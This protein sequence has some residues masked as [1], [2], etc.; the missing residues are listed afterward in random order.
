MAH[1]FKRFPE[2]TNSQMQ[3]YY[4]Q[5]PH[6]QITENFTATVVKVT[7]GDTIRVEWEGRD[8]D[9][10]V[11]FLDIAAAE[12]DEKGGTQSQ[13]WLENRILGK[14]IEVRINPTSRVEKWGRLLG[15]IYQDGLDVGKESVMLGFSVP[16]ARRDEGKV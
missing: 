6:R 8:F 7:D 1:D 11:R 10:P 14:D 15:A 13:K 5:S 16:W 12:L 4:F 3:F 9:F 2:L